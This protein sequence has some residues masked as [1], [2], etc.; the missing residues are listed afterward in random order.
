MQK[1]IEFTNTDRLV[2]FHIGSFH[3][4]DKTIL[5]AVD[6]IMKIFKKV[7]QR[8]CCQNAI[9][10]IKD[11]EMLCFKDQ[12][13]QHSL[14]FADTA[15]K[16]ED[17][18]LQAANVCQFHGYSIEMDSIVL[19]YQGIGCEANTAVYQITWPKSFLI[20]ELQI[21]ECT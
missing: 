16:L 10:L 4:L 15:L 20:A 8:S 7:C 14:Q 9:S 17:L 13:K 2:D 1:E 5:T 6:K 19:K 21:H 12:T 18:F 3:K 11:A